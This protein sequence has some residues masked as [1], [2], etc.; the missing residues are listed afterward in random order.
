MKGLKVVL[1]VIGI[2][3][4]V[5]SAPGTV[6]PWSSIVRGLT[7]IGLEAPPGHPVVV[8]CTRLSS[9][10]F[11]LVGVFF[12]VLAS[13]PLRYRPMLA[14]AVCGCFAVA[15]LALVAGCL[16]GMQPLWYLGDAVSCAVA[17]VLILAFW[18][19]GVQP[20]TVK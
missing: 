12:L 5:S 4:L 3:C 15:V 7:V 17:G 18:P 2:L 19:R 6:A 10:T 13:D 14:L 16:I 1:V 9:L 11:A 8:Y 20:A